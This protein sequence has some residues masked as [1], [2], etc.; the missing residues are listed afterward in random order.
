MFGI[1]RHITQIPT[2]SGPKRS[3]TLN[4]SYGYTI[5]FNSNTYVVNGQG[6]ALEWND[7]VTDP[8]S[9]TTLVG[10]RR[11]LPA[12][13]YSFVLSGSYNTG[14]NTFSSGQGQI[15]VNFVAGSSL[16]TLLYTTGTQVGG[17]Q[18]TYSATFTYTSATAFTVNPVL[19]SVNGMERPNNRP[20]LEITEL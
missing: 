7:G 17:T 2:A 13:S 15:R 8:D 16:G 1:Q 9:L 3:A 14:T 20:T 12:G 5:D 10:F 6:A 4:S 11:E 18:R 19:Y